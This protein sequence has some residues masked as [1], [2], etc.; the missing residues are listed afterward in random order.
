MD[1]ENR[2]NIVII[3]DAS[4][5]VSI[6]ADFQVD[7]DPQDDTTTDLEKRENTFKIT[8]KKR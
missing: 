4:Y 1:A 5:L 7:G 2:Y 6:F 8:I 3:H